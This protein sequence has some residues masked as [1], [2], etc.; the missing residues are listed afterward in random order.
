LQCWSDVKTLNA[1]LQKASAE[2]SEAIVD[3]AMKVDPHTMIPRLLVQIDQYIQELAMAY[4][5]LHNQFTA[6]ANDPEL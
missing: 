5:R 3:P 4:E 2:V 6:M 1:N